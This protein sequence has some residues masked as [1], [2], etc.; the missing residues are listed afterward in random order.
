MTPDVQ[1]NDKTLRGG[2]ARE[3]LLIG[4]IAA[5]LRL[6]LV[7]GGADV[8][9]VDDFHDAV[10][11]LAERA[12]DVVAVYPHAGQLGVDFVHAIKEGA[13]AHEH[14]LATLYGARGDADF[15]KGVRP[16]PADSLEA[17]RAR[18][19]STPFVLLPPGLAEE[20]AVIVVPPHATVIEHVRKKPVLTTLLT[21]S[22]QSVLSRGQAL[23]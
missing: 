21:V 12:F 19:A 13:T 16:P 20:Y 9:Q 17:A 14:T 10:L 8:T 22:A 18:H 4:E 11:A 2:R 15:L 6:G 7:E 23:A 5:Q 1:G 3:V